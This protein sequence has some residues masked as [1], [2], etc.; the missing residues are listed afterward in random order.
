MNILLE[1]ATELGK[2]LEVI[3]K[4]GHDFAIKLS[5]G[6]IARPVLA[7]DIMEH[8]DGVVERTVTSDTEMEQL[9]IYS[10]DYINCKG[11]K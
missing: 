11:A 7:F 8:E 5:N 4:K 6:K 2:N 10:V 3:D 1:C 9:G